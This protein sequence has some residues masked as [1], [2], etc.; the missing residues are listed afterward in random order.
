MGRLYALSSAL[1]GIHRGIWYYA[2]GLPVVP[3]APET[4][5]PY[6]HRASGKL[7]RSPGNPGIQQTEKGT[8]SVK[9]GFLQLCGHFYPRNP[10]A[11]TS[12]LDHA[13]EVAQASDF[14]NSLPDGLDSFV[15][16][17]GMNF[18]GGQKQRLSIAR[19]LVKRPE[20]YIF[21][22]SFP[23]LDFKT[24]AALRKALENETK[25]VAVLIIA[26]R[27]NT[28]RHAHQIIVLHEGKI[29]GKGTHEELM[30]NCAVYQEI[31]NSQTKEEEEEFRPK[32]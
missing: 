25:D 28:I 6:E 31:V 27:V 16:Q 13:L 5:G 2:D 9:Y 14:V 3:P 22:D 7:D 19:A 26:Q 23:A 18:S 1:R 30:A 12:E 21:D 15:A 17:G 32:K 24:A 8:G 4:S 20:L 29:V 10:D 11:T